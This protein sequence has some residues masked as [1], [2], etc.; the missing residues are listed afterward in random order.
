MRLVFWGTPAF[1]VP[2]LEALHGAGHEVVLVVTPPDRPAGRGRRLQAPAVKVAAL[3]LGLP[4]VQP[5]S[6]RGD[7]FREVLVDARPELS[8]VVAYGHILP[9]SVLD[10]P[11]L[12]SINLHASLLP[13][14]R[15]AAPVVWALRL[16]MPKTGVTV[17]RMVEKMDA[18]PIIHALEIPVNARE[19]AT[20]LG[21]R[22]SQ[23]GSTALLEAIGRFEAGSVHEVAQD[24]SRATFAPKLTRAQARIDWKE[25]AAR[26]AR[27]VRGMDSVPGAWS[28]LRGQ[29]VKL[30]RPWVMSRSVDGGDAAE[31]RN[32]IRAG[33]PGTVVSADPSAGLTV[34]TANGA[35][36]FGEVQPPG[37]RRMTARSW[38]AGRG[39]TAGDR[40]E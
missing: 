16:G 21:I 30:F 14:L 25:G 39:I 6:P 1:A 13:E 33:I 27:L 18:G 34:A 10:I 32:D 9:R 11:T 36:G 22:L 31:T 8:V 19:S 40:F 23:I 5:D 17:I 4:V 2:S 24:H 26:I 35:V 7:T 29:P 38:I 12:G 28:T 15:G 20:E 3:A 37:R